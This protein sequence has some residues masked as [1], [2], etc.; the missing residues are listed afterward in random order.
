MISQTAY[1][2][3]VAVGLTRG[4]LP[5]TVYSLLLDTFELDVFAGIPHDNAHTDDVIGIQYESTYG[6]SSSELTWDE[7]EIQHL[8][9]KFL[10]LTGKEAKVFLCTHGY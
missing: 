2:A 8:K 1:K 10:M 5:R 9:N 6:F 7:V 4:E 3:V